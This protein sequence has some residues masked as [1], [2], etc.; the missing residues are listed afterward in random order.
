MANK[1]SYSEYLTNYA[2]SLLAMEISQDFIDNVL[3]VNEKFISTYQNILEIID[4]INMNINPN[5][6]IKKIA[7]QSG[8]NDDKHFMK[9]FKKFE[10]VTP[11]QYR[12]AYFRKNINKL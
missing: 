4:W 12:N 8:F 9:L 3:F 11:T 5:I 6:S 2:L 10:D 7:K 1:K